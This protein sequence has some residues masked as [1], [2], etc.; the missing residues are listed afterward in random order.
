VTPHSPE[1]QF[2]LSVIRRQA[3]RPCSFSRSETGFD[4]FARIIHRVAQLDRQNLRLIERE[5]GL[6]LAEGFF[7]EVCRWKL[8]LFSAVWFSEK[9]PLLAWRFRSQVP[10]RS[11][12]LAAGRDLEA[13]IEAAI[14]PYRRIG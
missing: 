12:L 9:L 1:L 4:E 10:S 11:R 5:V 8:C 7:C 13:E 6:L 14:Y 2:L 3:E